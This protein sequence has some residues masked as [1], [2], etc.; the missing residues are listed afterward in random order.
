MSLDVLAA[1]GASALA[2]LARQTK[3]IPIVFAV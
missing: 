2:A 1:N 3:T